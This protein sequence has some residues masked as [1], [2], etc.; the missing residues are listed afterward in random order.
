[1]G[2]TTYLLVALHCTIC[3]HI[4]VVL[5]VVSVKIILRSESVIVVVLPPAMDQG[6]CVSSKI[7]T[8]L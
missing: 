2:F 3:S 8:R 5:N 7:L 6:K 4:G 1:M